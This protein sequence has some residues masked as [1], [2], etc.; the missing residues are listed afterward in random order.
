[1]PWFRVDDQIHSHPKARRA[2]LAAMGLWA[3]AGSHCMNYLTDGVVESWFV[4]AWPDG[5]AL[6]ARLVEVGLWRQHPQGWEFHDWDGYQPSREKLL[7]ER[8]AG[9]V[10]VAKHRERKAGNAAGNAVT[11]GERTEYVHLPQSQ[12]HTQTS[13]KTFQRQSRSNRAR[14]STDAE[15][16]PEMTRRLAAQQGIHDLPGLVE[17]IDDQLGRRIDANRAY[18]L[19][20]HL[21]GKARDHP[22]APQRYV[23]ACIEQSP[24]EVQKWIDEAA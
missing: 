22:D 6:A 10:R 19:A 15:E 3:L 9:R 17:R 21:L 8:E 1:M 4:E 18:Q 13:S 12:S 24:F 5:P 16:V 14:V 7:A 2:G 23:E 11:N 20:L